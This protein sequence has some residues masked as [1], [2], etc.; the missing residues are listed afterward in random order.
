MHIAVRNFGENKGRGL[1]YNPRQIYSG[2][3]E[4][5][6]HIYEKFFQ[7]GNFTL[8]SIMTRQGPGELA[9]ILA[10]EFGV[11]SNFGIGGI[12]APFNATY[13]QAR[14]LIEDLEANPKRYY[15][16][17]EEKWFTEKPKKISQ[18]RKLLK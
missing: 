6:E 3:N 14:S 8:V 11:E 4:F 17:E 1:V 7:Q 10:R 12:I 5:S 15:E 18:K 16:S 2:L 13:E 9:K